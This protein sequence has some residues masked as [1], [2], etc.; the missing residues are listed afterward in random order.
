MNTTIRKGKVPFYGDHVFTHGIS[1]SGFFNK[2]E[3]EELLIYGHTLSALANG[4]LTPENA[5]EQLFIE[6]ISSS[7]P[8]TLYLAT[9]WQKYTASVMKS[10]MH[11]GFAKSSAKSTYTQNNDLEFA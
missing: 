7:E 4:T 5:D 2:R 3:S 6:Q 8:A 10:K 9:L 1:R 11:H